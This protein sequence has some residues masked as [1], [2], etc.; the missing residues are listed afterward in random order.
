MGI[1]EKGKLTLDFMNRM[2]KEYDQLK[3]EIEKDN[4]DDNKI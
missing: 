1:K 3:S 4:V 2:M